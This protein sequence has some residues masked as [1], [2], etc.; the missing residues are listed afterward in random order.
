MINLLLIPYV[1]FKII[2]IL[3]IYQQSR[4]NIKSYMIYMIRNFLYINLLPLA[5]LI[6]SIIIPD[7][8]VISYI[9]VSLYSIFY[10]RHKVRLCLTNRIK[11]LIISLF[12]LIIL[13]I[14]PLVLILIE[15]I[16]IAIM[17]LMS[18]LERLIS[19]HYIRQCAIKLNKYKGIKIAITGSYGKTSTKHILN[20]C[21]T[22]IYPTLAMPKSYN[23]PLGIAKIINSTNIDKYNILIFEMGATK[24]GDISELMDIIRPNISIITEVGNMHLDSFKSINNILNEKCKAS[25]LIKG[26]SIINVENELLREYD[27][28]NKIIGYGINFGL[29][30]IK[31]IDDKV[32]ELYCDGVYFDTYKCNM[33]GIFN[34]L[35]MVSAIIVMNILGIDKFRIKEGID[36]VFN[37][38]SRLFINNYN[39]MILINDGYNSNLTGAREAIRVLNSYKGYKI[40]ITPLFVEMKIDCI[41]YYNDMIKYCDLILLV[42]YYE[43]LEAY[44]YLVGKANVYI[45][46]SLK[47]AI[48]IA[49]HISK[50]IKTV[51]LIENDLPDIYRKGF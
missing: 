28:K 14:C 16:S 8:K 26:I 3:R 4:Y 25:D 7:S 27:F 47:E 24:V 12:I 22:K 29:Y 1:I 11:R 30:R 37:P 46:N 42:G 18:I 31:P 38:P 15:Y 33:N 50:R 2:L 40:L 17:F 51:V 6:V 43:T 21:L 5:I 44:D 36:S 39:N 20:H 41:E 9:L 45:V 32:F 35:N 23:T 19:K 10:L 13:I 49:S 34:K 48:N